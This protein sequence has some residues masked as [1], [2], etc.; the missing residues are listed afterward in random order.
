MKEI[1]QLGN[2]EKHLIFLPGGNIDIHC[3]LPLLKRLTKHYSV[4]GVNLL[5]LGTANLSES[6]KW[7]EE[8]INECSSYP[9][10]IV[11]HSLGADIVKEINS[12][13]ITKSILFN[14]SIYNPHYSKVNVIF[15]TLLKSL[16]API[17]YPHLFIFY[18]RANYYLLKNLVT[19]P[20]KTILHIKQAL[21]NITNE[22][23]VTKPIPNDKLIVI[24]SEKDEYF[25]NPQQTNVQIVDGNHEWLMDDIQ[26]SSEFIQNLINS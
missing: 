19:K 20:R 21:N 15:I 12:D 26:K 1:V 10:I 25:P 16:L 8:Y 9:T 17:K 14:S 7:L 13:K 6:R 2:S 22:L 23:Q 4:D 3:Y 24:A 11:A 18:V 5:E